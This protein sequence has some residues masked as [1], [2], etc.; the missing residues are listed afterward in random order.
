MNSKTQCP[1]F[2]EKKQLSL[3]QVAIVPKRNNQAAAHYAT[4]LKEWLQLRNISTVYNQILAD[5]DLVIVLGGD[6]TLLHIAEQAARYAI[7]VLGI[8]FGTLGFLSDR[9]EAEALQALEKIIETEIV[10]ENRLMLQARILYA[11][12][13]PSDTRYLLNDVVISKNTLDPVLNL[14]TVADDEFITTYK[15]DGLIF[16]T[17]TGSTAYNL[18]AGGPLVYPGLN[19]I[20]ITPI[21]PFM[22]S[23]RP[24]ILPAC[25]RILTRLADDSDYSAQILI[26]GRSCWQ[27]TTGDTLEIVPASH[28]LQLA[29]TSSRSYFTVLR[30]KLHWG[31]AAEKKELY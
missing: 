30:N 21:C 8:N 6:G 16:S 4:K 1:P 10:I 13:M 9:T 22:L 27:L 26:D 25:T 3:K 20:T 14:H 31:E 23:S 15:A 5:C 2:R 29:V 19:T 12:D 11:A 18:S 7:P 17:P 28:S 24:V